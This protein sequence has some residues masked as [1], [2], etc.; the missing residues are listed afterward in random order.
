MFSFCGRITTPVNEKVS[1]SLIS[2]LSRHFG[3]GVRKRGEDYHKMGRVVIDSGTPN[4]VNARVK[5]SERYNVEISLTGPIL[6]TYCSCPYIVSMDQPCK[7]IWAVVLESDRRQFLSDVEKAEPLRLEL[8]GDDH[9]SDEDLDNDG[10]AVVPV[11]ARKLANAAARTPY[12]N[13]P[14]PVNAGRKSNARLEVPEWKAPRLLR[15]SQHSPHGGAGGGNGVRGQWPSGRVIY[16]VFDVNAIRTGNL[17]VSVCFREPKADGTLGKMRAERLPNPDCFPDPADRQIM[18]LL[19]TSSQYDSYGYNGETASFDR[20]LHAASLD[21]VLP[22][23]CATGRCLLRK[24]NTW[25]ELRPIQWDDGPPWVFRMRVQSY[26][27]DDTYVV[28]GVLQR[29]AELVSL[30]QCV[31]PLSGGVIFFKDCAAR[32]D[33]GGAFPWMTF[34]L[35]EK[36]APIPRKHGEEFLETLLSSGKLPPLDLPEELKVDCVTVEPRTRLTVRPKPH[37]PEILT[38]ELYFDF[39]GKNRRRVRSHRPHLP[40]ETSAAC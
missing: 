6:R 37:F 13:Y 4:R 29:G 19:S 40:K 12:G 38:G 24:E 15:L 33:H 9:I 27:I 10:D 3:R 30:S 34:L 14:K 11:Y 26:E 35:E 8:S 5:G 16:Y 31:L 28:S 36:Q 1:M 18:A 32:L 23:L 25:E 39:D 21:I 22:K 17:H 20:P 7:H 2:K